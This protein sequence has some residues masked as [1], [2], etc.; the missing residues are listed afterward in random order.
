MSWKREE[1]SDHKFDFVD[2]DEFIDNS[3]QRRIAYSTVFIFA[4]KGIISI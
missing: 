1:I 3:I 2:V 4:I